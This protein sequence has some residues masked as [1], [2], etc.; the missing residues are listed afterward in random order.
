M[1]HDLYYLV[2]LFL[3]SPTNSEAGENPVTSALAQLNNRNSL[4]FTEEDLNLDI[5]YN[6]QVTA[7]DQQQLQTVLNNVLGQNGLNLAQLSTWL[8]AVATA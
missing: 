2:V 3:S 7:M 1:I 5:L 4:L 8:N 6:Q